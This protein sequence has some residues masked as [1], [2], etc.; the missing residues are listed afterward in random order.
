MLKGATIEE[1]FSWLSY[2]CLDAFFDVMKHVCRELQQFLPLVLLRID[3]DGGWIVGQACHFEGTESGGRIAAATE[4]LFVQLENAV[5]LL[6]L[7]RILTVVFLYSHQGNVLLV[8][9]VLDLQ[10]IDERTE[11]VKQSL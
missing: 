3:F 8:D 1:A 9:L 5:L 6:S 4:T 7:H 2:I 10:M 11:V